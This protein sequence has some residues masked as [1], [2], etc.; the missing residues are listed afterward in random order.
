MFLQYAESSRVLGARVVPL[1]CFFFEREF[2]KKCRKRKKKTPKRHFF[3]F[4]IFF[5]N[6]AATEMVSP[7][8]SPFG[9]FRSFLF[10][11]FSFRTRETAVL[12]FPPVDAS[13]QLTKLTRE[14]TI[15]KNKTDDCRSRRRRRS[16]SVGRERHARRP[17]AAGVFLFFTLRRQQNDFLVTVRPGVLR[18]TKGGKL[19][20]EARSRRKKK[21]N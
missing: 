14:K 2:C 12:R 16:A 4:F 15:Q 5:L 19:W 9:S 18:Q 13:D 11:S 20:V 8:P 6:F 7:S 10:S 21:K 1:R 17:G 3:L